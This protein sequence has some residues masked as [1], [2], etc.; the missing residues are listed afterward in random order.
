M[1]LEEQLIELLDPKHDYSDVKFRQDGSVWFMESAKVYQLPIAD[2][3]HGASFKQVQQTL[4]ALCPNQ[5]KARQWLE[6]RMNAYDDGITLGTTRLRLAMTKTTLGGEEITLRIL[7]PKI[8]S[9]S[10]LLIPR[11]IVDRNRTLADGITLVVGTTGHGKSTTVAAL[12][13]DRVNHRE[14]GGSVTTFEDPIEYVYEER[15]DV[16]FSQYQLGV[17]FTDF[18][19]GVAEITTRNRTQD[20]VVQEIRRQESGKSMIPTLVDASQAGRYVIATYHAED[21]CRCVDRLHNELAET[22]Y[23]ASWQGLCGQLRMIIAQRLVFSQ[24]HRRYYAIHEVLHIFPNEDN[25]NRLL[26]DR[27]FEQLR[28]RMK[29]G[30]SI[31]NQTFEMSRETRIQDGVL[32]GGLALP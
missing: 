15:N 11:S 4:L 29:T 8:P 1:E 31:G 19:S 22:G 10:D 24:R 17:D 28:S 18:I 6:S 9:P 13:Q 21:V 7:P 5:T 32:D 25:T 16:W 23:M 2:V 27:N 30:K 26:A 20:I 3:L 12:V 14:G